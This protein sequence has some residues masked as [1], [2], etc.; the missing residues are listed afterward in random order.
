MKKN[1]SRLTV[2]GIVALGGVL[3]GCHREVVETNPDY[4]PETKEVTTQFVLNVTA[5]PQTKMSASTVQLAK[6]FRGIEDAKL[7]TFKT[8]QT[9]V[10][11]VLAT[12]TAP[13]KDFDLGLFLPSNGLDNGTTGEGTS[14][15]N[16]NDTESSRRVLQLSLPVSTDAVLFYGKAIKATGAESKEL[17]A[18]N[19]SYDANKTPAGTTFSAQKILGTTA[20][21]NQY[22]ATARLMIAVINDILSRGVTANGSVTVGTGANAIVFDNLPA[23]TWAQLG[24]QYELD[25]FPTESRYENSQNNITN[26]IILGHPLEGL[27]E[28][29][30]KCYYLFTYITP[31]DISATPGS[32]EWTAAVGTATRPLGEYRAGSSAA[33]KSQIIDMYKVIT[34]ASSTDPGNAREANAKRLAKVILDRALLY[35]DADNGNYKDVSEIKELLLQYGVITSTEW[36]N[37]YEGALSLNGYPYEDFGVPEGA[38]QLGFHVYGTARPSSDGGGTYPKDEFYYYHPNKPLVNPTMAEFEPRKYLYPAELWYYVNS[39]IRIT[40]KDVTID[41]YPNGVTPWNSSTSWTDWTNPGGKVTSGTRGVAVVDNINYGVALLK[42]S[43]VY[44]DGVTVL[45]DNRKKLTNNVEDNK[46][47][48]VSSAQLQLR[49]ILIGGVN[50]RM[51]WQFTRKYTSTGNHENLGDLSLFDGVIYDHTLPSTAV[52]NAA[53]PNYTLVYDNYNSSENQA[54]QN[55]VYV[56]LEFVNGGDAFWGRDN[57]IPHDGVFYLVAKMPKPTAEQ[58]NTLSSRWP[59]DHQIPPVWGVD[60]EN[61]G[62]NTKGQS[63]KIARVFIQDFVTTATFKIGATSLQ[64]AYY[65]VPDLRASQMSLGLSVD[66]EWTQGIDYTLSL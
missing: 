1:L 13:D 7:F 48:N 25:H 10:P 22:D 9:G 35:F 51:N 14:A 53:S 26:G 55:D 45:Q 31:S 36:T 57:L 8:G 60:G 24:H 3:V 47:I 41:S 21:V 18:T 11:Y 15:T 66:L 42:S 38:A 65:S 54:G 33:V 5:A 27:E 64:N 63:K 44:D 50:P 61:V 4:N 28:V 6:N 52:P 43:V 20:V 23:I 49:G 39:P 2:L 58:I 59:T 16:N 34:A 40:E 46:T 56:S 30:G 62:T 32:A 17:G 29:L 12:A 19:V 37:N